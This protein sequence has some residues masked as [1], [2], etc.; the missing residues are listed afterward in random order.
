MKEQV[1][2]LCSDFNSDQQCRKDICKQENVANEL[3]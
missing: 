2:E 1:T 3:S